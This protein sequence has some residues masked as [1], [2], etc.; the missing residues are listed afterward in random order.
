MFIDVVRV[1]IIVSMTI[2][3]SEWYF[4][5]S[6]GLLER[7]FLSGNFSREREKKCQ[8]NNEKKNIVHLEKSPTCFEIRKHAT[9]K[10]ECITR[11]SYANGHLHY[12]LAVIHLELF[13]LWK[14]SM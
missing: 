4:S 8:Q 5:S 3:L 12:T 2:F 13:M 6:A 14:K 7:C 10:S 11:G 1:L 9:S